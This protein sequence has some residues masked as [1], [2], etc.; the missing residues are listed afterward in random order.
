VFACIIII[1]GPTN[2]YL[3]SIPSTPLE[4]HLDLVFWFV[5][6]QYFPGIL[7]TDTKEKLGWN[8]SV[9]Y[10]SQESLFSSK[11]GFRPLF[12]EPSPPFEGKKSSHQIYK[13]E[14]PQ[15]FTKWSS[16]QILQYKN[17]KPNIPT[18]KC[19]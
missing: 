19:R 14:F 12:D 7:P 5:I 9:L 13:K 15:N 1:L 3:T 10:I 17:T 8:V 4:S 2:L 11:G 16:R 18:G 6:G